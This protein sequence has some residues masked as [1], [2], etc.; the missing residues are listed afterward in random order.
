[1]RD[2]AILSASGSHKWL[3]CTASSRLEQLIE[4]TTTTFA[5]EGTLAHALG[6]A[7]LR[8]DELDINKLKDDELFYPGML[9]EVEEYVN[10]CIERF[11][12]IKVVDPIGAAIYIE[13]RLNLTDYVPEGFG[14]GDCIVIGNGVLEIIDLKFGKGVTVDV[15]ENPQLMLYALGALKEF[16]FLYDIHTVR[17][18]IAQVRTIGITS[19]EMK[20]TDLEYWAENVL[21]PKAEEAYKG[22]GEPTPGEWCRNNFCKYRFN[23]K[24]YSEMLLEP[25]NKYHGK[26]ALS[27]NEISEILQSADTVVKWINELKDYAL[28]EALQGVIFPGFKVVEGISRRTIKNDMEFANLLVASGYEEDK[29]FKPRAIETLGKLEKL[30]GKKKLAELGENYI[31]K[32]DGKPTLVPESDKRPARDTV[33]EEF[34]FE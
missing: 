3:H 26:D 17:M 16:G 11:N 34:D 20:V 6:E 30:V 24:A 32:P 9:D 27:T 2:H 10:Y 8:N 5:E 22:E 1:M 23:C 33:E 15:N 25:F 13:Q 4:D 12:E 19:Y 29:V 7:M 28:S 31:Y 21:K 14:T 18:T